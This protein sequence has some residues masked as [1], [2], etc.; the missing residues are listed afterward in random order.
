MRA[1][2]ILLAAMSGVAP[3]LCAQQGTTP[4]IAIKATAKGEMP[5]SPRRLPTARCATKRA[6]F[7]S[8]RLTQIRGANRCGPPCR[9]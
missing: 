1:Q 3:M 4:V 9:K 6:M 5:T 2:F 8:G 7:T